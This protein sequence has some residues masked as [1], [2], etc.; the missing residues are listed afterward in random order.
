MRS[1]SVS[2]IE[3]YLRCREE[4]RLAYVEGWR[5]HVPAPELRFGT[6]VHAGLARWSQTRSLGA[7]TR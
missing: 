3:V 6:T 4:H 1:V 5:L 2:E 7:A